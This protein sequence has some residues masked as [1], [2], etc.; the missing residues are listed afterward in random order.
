[1]SGRLGALEAGGLFRPRADPPWLSLS[2]LVGALP[3]LSEPLATARVPSFPGD[4]P[5]KLAEDAQK[6]LGGARHKPHSPIQS[7]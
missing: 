7:S 2:K 3:C 6:T 4:A 1:M 5:P